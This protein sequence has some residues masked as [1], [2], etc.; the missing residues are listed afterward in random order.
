[1]S[2]LGFQ[3]GLVVSAVAAL[4]CVYVLG[5][6]LIERRPILNRRTARIGWALYFVVLAVAYGLLEAAL[7]SV[8]PAPRFFILMVSIFGLLA[9]VA[10]N[11][12][13]DLNYPPH[14]GPPRRDDD[15]T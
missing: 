2:D 15:N 6:N 4:T 8:D 10:W 9:A 13:G 5:K 3:I 1:M 7:A 12:A 14:G 11:P